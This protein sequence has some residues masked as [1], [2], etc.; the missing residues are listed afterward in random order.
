MDRRFQQ[1]APV[2]ARP[3]YAT[4]DQLTRCVR[5]IHQNVKRSF[6]HDTSQT[7]ARD[8][9]QRKHGPDPWVEAL[10]S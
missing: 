8:V 5:M 9:V 4:Y 1:V 3:T 6:R 2:I 7:G 10:P